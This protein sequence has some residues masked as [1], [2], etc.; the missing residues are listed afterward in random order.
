MAHLYV[1]EFHLNKKEKAGG[2]PQTPHAAQ[3]VCGQRAI[4]FPLHGTAPL[5]PAAPSLVE[6]SEFTQLR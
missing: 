3:L 1:C 2:G 4:S 6:D 5:M